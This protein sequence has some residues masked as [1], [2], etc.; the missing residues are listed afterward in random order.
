[1]NIRLEINDI[2]P[3][4]LQIEDGATDQYPQAVIYDDNDNLLTTLNLSHKNNGL[5]APSSQ[6]TMPD[7]DYISV[8]YIVYSDSGHTTESAVYLRDVDIFK[9]VVPDNYKATGFAVPNEYDA[10]LTAI[11]ADLNNPDQYK[12]N[13][14][15][16]ALE[17]NIEGHV[18]TAL[19]T[20]DPPTRAELTSD[21]NEII[22][23]VNANEIKLDIIQA[24]LDNPDQ[25]KADVT[26]LDVLVSSRSS[27]TAADVWAV[28][29]RTLTGFGTLIADIWASATRTLTAGTKDAEIDAIKTETDKIPAI[30]IDQT[31]IKDIEG[32]DWKIDYTN[33]QMIFKKPGGAEV[34]RFDLTDINGD[35]ITATTY[36][37]ERVRV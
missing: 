26:N 19:N 13:V 8:T 25:Y 36:P 4:V 31:F 17:A 1:M 11:Q 28:T 14:S 20:Y 6:Y 33:S 23:E 9:K 3:I 32:G 29:T 12:A 5:Y 35:P 22:T 18:T 27:H 16:L 21:K 34:A 15:T 37:S 7:E 30:I 24:D 10:E 2:V